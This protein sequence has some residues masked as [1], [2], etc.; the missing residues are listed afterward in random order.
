MKL[1]LKMKLAVTV[2][3][4]L[5]APSVCLRC[6]LLA[7]RIVRHDSH[8]RRFCRLRLLCCDPPAPSKHSQP[9][10]VQHRGPRAQLRVS[11]QLFHGRSTLVDICCA[12]NKNRRYC[13][14]PPHVVKPLLLQ[15]SECDCLQGQKAAAIQEDINDRQSHNPQQSYF[16]TTSE[17]KLLIVDEKHM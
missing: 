2:H 4:F 9:C 12:A 16:M 14:L 1:R 13:N 15:Y 17:K 10:S 8:Q 5:S 11:V 6:R 7:V 3:R